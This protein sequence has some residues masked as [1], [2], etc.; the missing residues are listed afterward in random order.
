LGDRAVSSEIEDSNSIPAAALYASYS[1]EFMEGR[2]FYWSRG[3]CDFV[4]LDKFRL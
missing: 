1:K 4:F 3:V 2:W